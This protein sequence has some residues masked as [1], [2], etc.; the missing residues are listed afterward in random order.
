MQSALLEPRQKG[1]HIKAAPKNYKTRK[2][3]QKKKRKKKRLNS[4]RA[5]APCNEMR[6]SKSQNS[7]EELRFIQN[8]GNKIF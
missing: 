8:L 3:K 1:P 7:C 2:R 4:Y 5:K 6:I